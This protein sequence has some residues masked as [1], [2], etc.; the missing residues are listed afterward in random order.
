MAINIERLTPVFA[1][2]PGEV[3]KDELESREIKQKDFAELTGLLPSQLNEILNGKRGIN[4]DYALVIGKALGMDPVIWLKLQNNY[5][6]DKAKLNDKTRKR[7]DAIGQWQMVQPYIPELYF[8]KQGYLKGDPLDDL[9]MIKQ[10]YR[11]EHLDKIPAALNRPAYARYRKS[12]TA[13][14]DQINLFGWANLVI[15]KAESIQ[16]A[17]FNKDSQ[18]FVIEK[19]KDIFF[20]NQRT[21]QKLHSF[22]HEYG[23]K[24]VILEQPEKCAVDGF[25]FWSDGNPAIGLSMR[26]QRI[27]YL[28]FTVFH[29]LGHVYKHLINSN[30]AEFLDI[31]TE[32][33]IDKSKEEQEANDF[34]KDSLINPISW[35]TYFSSPTKLQE[36][37]MLKLARKERIH[38][39]IV[40]GRLSHETG[41]YRIRTRFENTIQ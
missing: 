35:E 26:F 29:E 12:P 41:N 1:I 30:T 40:K 33:A 13:T 7:L 6:L 21:V 25:A 38:P 3:L 36:L 4:A 23:I 28:A 17:S 9:D 27:D 2:H 14:V 15:H 10:I 37:E 16:V 31:D 34:A 18:F 39:A 8:K 5:E 11:V 32:K 22:L 24:M 20:K 19:V